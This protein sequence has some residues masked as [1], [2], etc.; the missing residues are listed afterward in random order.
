M[1]IDTESDESNFQ[2]VRLA[3]KG[4]FDIEWSVLEP[5]DEDPTR[6]WLRLYSRGEMTR[7]WGN[8]APVEGNDD[9][10]ATTHPKHYIL[11]ACWTGHV[12]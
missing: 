8:Y 10:E 1:S 5:C 9:K 4:G 11:R 6:S 3:A 2:Y 12:A 7:C